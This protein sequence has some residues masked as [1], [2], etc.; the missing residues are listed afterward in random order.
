MGR[1]TEK[2]HYI[3]AARGIAILMVVICHAVQPYRSSIGRIWTD[4]A[5]AGQYGVQLFFAA[6]A[7]TLCMAWERDSRLGPFWVRR[8]F[9]IA[10]M[11]YL[12]ILLYWALFSA[13]GEA[14]A[15]TAINVGANAALVHG[16][17]PAAHNSIVP[18][19]WSIGTEVAFYAFFPFIIGPVLRLGRMSDWALPALAC[20]W[21]ILVGLAWRWTTE[22][23][24]FRYHSLLMQLPVFLLGF[25][26]YLRPVMNWRR[27]LLAVLLVAF[28]WSV[29]WK[30]RSGNPLMLGLVAAILLRALRHIAA[31]PA[32]LRN[33]GQVSFSMYV[34]HFVPAFFVAPWMVSRIDSQAAAAIL[35]ISL[36]ILISYVVAKVT[37]AAVERPMIKLGKRLS[38]RQFS[39]A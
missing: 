8:A 31:S 15:Y 20:A 10:P 36:T 24:E 12:G 30:L 13:R 27:D 22:N 38:S 37:E 6:S 26:V 33:V 7:L 3:D 28:C 5:M 14:D 34:V 39:A 4:I 25:W 1:E 21:S 18:G 35:G 19:G 32:W 17:I 9:R 23:A 2:V 29:T 16:F 11:Y